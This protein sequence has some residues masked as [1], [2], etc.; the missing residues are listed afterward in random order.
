MKKNLLISYKFWIVLVTIALVQ[1]CS[2]PQ[3][4]QK[5]AS[6][7]TPT[8]FKGVKD[9]TNSAQIKWKEFF[10]DPYLVALIDTA[11]KNNQE[12][13]IVL[14]EINIAQNEIKARSGAY[15]PFV[16]VGA[17]IGAEKAGRYTRTG[18]VD[19]NV[20]MTPDQAIPE[21]LTD[22]AVTANVSWQVDIWKQL[23]NAKK[24][25]VYR[26]LATV[27]GRNFLITNLVAEVAYTY[28]E[29]VALDAELEIIEKNIAIQQNALRIVSLK[30]VAGEVTELAVKRFQAEVS[31]NQSQKYYLMQ[32]I[33]EN[34]NRI[35]FLLGRFPQPVARASFNAL[36]P[37]SLEAGIPSQLLANRPDIR[38]AELQLAANQLDISVAKANFY[39]VLNITSKIGFQAFNPKYI[40]TTPESML[41]NLMGEL[42][43]PLVNR[44]AIKAEYM[45]ANAR[46]IQAAYNYER[47]ILNAFTEVTN[48][49]AKI[50]NL[51][52]SYKAKEQQVE[53]LNQSINISI[54][55]FNSARAD[56]VEILLTQRDAIESKLQL[57]EIRQEQFNNT[58]KMYQALGGGWQ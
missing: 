40:I 22:F 41:F 38:Q 29:L 39:P 2:L 47:T 5:T 53:A 31:K 17:G 33:I 27:E 16:N 14:Q 32:Q 49:I 36:T 35:N 18:A 52:H 26:Y 6:K 50:E 44:N 28:Y 8:T 9:S 7:K 15:L 4:V 57:V 46:Q 23:R 43:A 45:S 51:G 55:L 34:E 30:K 42:V 13:N 1:A 12:L 3:L 56:Y 21:V 58:I 37:H 48:Q 11:L 20:N 10:T 19:A 54:N 24:S 25:A